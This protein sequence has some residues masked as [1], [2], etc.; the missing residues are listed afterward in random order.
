MSN[1][2]QHRAI[3]AGSILFEIIAAIILILVIA[4]QPAKAYAD[5]GSGAVMWQL[6]LASIVSVGFHFRKLRSW[7][8]GRRP[9]R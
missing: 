1:S 5:P 7:F 4:E 9:R 3:Q 8:A 2:K 6:L